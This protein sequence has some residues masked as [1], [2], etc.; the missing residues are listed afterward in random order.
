MIKFI[1]LL[2]CVFLAT[3][4]VACNSLETQI[5][6][7]QPAPVNISRGLAEVM[8][9]H[10]G[11]PVIIRRNP[12]SQHRISGDYAMASRPCPP[13]CIH[14]FQIEGDIETIGEL[15]ML[16]YLQLASNSDAVLVVDSRTEDWTLKGTIPGST[17]IPWK[18]L[19]TDTSDPLTIMGL[20]EE[21]FNVDTSDTLWDFSQAK[22][23]VLFCNGIWCNQ[24]PQNL[25]T[26]LNLGYP[27]EKLKWYRGGVQSWVQLGLPLVQP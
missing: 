5:V 25:T 7:P 4:L 9:I 22:T 6:D 3:G 2:G 13:R 20:L 12:D 8:V 18:L 24:S 27:H 19:K 21:E 17:S 16:H 11:K 10:N 1:T 26:L 23:L 15:E 14:P